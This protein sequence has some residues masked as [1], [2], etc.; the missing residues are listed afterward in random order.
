MRFPIHV[1]AKAH[2]ADRTEVTAREHT[3]TIDEPK[4]RGGTDSG[5]TPLETLMA[6]LAGCTTVIL[7][8][9]AGERGW[10]VAD[11]EIDVTGHLDPRAIR[12][13]TPVPVAFPEIDLRIAGRI[14]GDD[15]DLQAL[16]DELA[17]RCPV[18]ALLRASG[19]DIREDWTSIGLSKPI[20]LGGSVH[21]SRS[22]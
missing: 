17:F 14:T 19:S 3:I 9:I 15:V 21:K 1:A 6:A 13:G 2:S 11:L 5:P 20:N 22:R 16:R 10:I 18:S 7:N 8:K 4:S 12:T